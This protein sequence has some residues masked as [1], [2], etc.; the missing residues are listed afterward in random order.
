MTEA[1]KE[2]KAACDE[3]LADAVPAMERSKEAV[4]CLT[5]T[6]I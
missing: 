2:Q 1:A 5:L 3:E 6:S 4:A